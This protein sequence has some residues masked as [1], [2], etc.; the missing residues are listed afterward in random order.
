MSTPSFLIYG[1]VR[2]QLTESNTLVY[3]YSYVYT[4]YEKHSKG[5]KTTSIL[6]YFLPKRKKKSLIKSN[7]THWT[8]NIITIKALMLKPG[9]GN[10]QKVGPSAVRPVAIAARPSSCQPSSRCFFFVVFFPPFPPPFRPSAF[11]R[12]SQL[13]IHDLHRP[14]VAPPEFPLHRAAGPPPTPEP[15]AQSQRRGGESPVATDTSQSVGFNCGGIFLPYR[16]VLKL[17]VRRTDERDL[18]VIPL[19]IHKGSSWALGSFCCSR[20]RSLIR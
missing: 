18:V 8:F 13:S 19:D 12:G 20:G 17:N 11:L 4:V 14:A 5:R 9:R 6:L 1:S 15:P 7:I 10:V 16:L 2:W 3:V